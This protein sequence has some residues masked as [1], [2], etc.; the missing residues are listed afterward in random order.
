MSQ[1]KDFSSEHTS[2]IR[3]WEREEDRRKQIAEH[4]ESEV[5]KAL[6]GIMGNGDNRRNVAKDLKE[7]AES[8][9]RIEDREGYGRDDELV[10]GY[11]DRP[12][13]RD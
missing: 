6:R 5:K 3:K 10:T 2:T 4:M 12:W 8:G 9:R 1:E 11:E 7:A 13:E